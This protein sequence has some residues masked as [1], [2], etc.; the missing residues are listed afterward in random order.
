MN[1]RKVDMVGS[2]GCAGVTLLISLM[3]GTGCRRCT[4]AGVKEGEG[5]KWHVQ[6]V[7]ACLPKWK[8]RMGW[9]GQVR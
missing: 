5:V 3:S 1:V 9:S 8:T 4:S 7:K 6:G 2:C